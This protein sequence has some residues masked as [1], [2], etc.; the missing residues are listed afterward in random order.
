MSVFESVSLQLSVAR[1][2][3]TVFFWSVVAT[4]VLQVVGEALSDERFALD[5]R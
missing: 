2:G 5:D 3:Q 4:F 1:D